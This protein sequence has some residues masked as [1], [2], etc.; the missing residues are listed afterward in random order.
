ML[1]WRANCSRGLKGDVEEF[2][3]RFAVLET[4]RDHSKSQC[5]DDRNRFIPVPSV[6]QHAR[7]GR[8][9]GDPATVFF[10]FEL[11][12]EGHTRTVPSRPRSAKLSSCPT[13]ESCGRADVRRANPAEV[14][15]PVVP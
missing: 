1:W 3:W 2:G 14:S 9:L 10:A 8:H 13:R 12:R 11:D 4:L 6:A 15:R 5:L 7:E